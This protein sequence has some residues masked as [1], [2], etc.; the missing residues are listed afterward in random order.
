MVKSAIVGLSLLRAV[1]PVDFDPTDDAAITG[2]AAGQLPHHVELLRVQQLLLGSTPRLLRLQAV[3][4]IDSDGQ[5]GGPAVVVDPP[6]GQFDID[7]R[8][9]PIAGPL[10]GDDGRNVRREFAAA[11]RKHRE[12]LRQGGV[13]IQL[14]AILPRGRVVVGVGFTRGAGALIFK[15]KTYPFSIQGLSVLDVSAYSGLASPVDVV[16]RESGTF[17]K[18]NLRQLR[19][20]TASRPELRANL[21]PNGPLG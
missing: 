17:A 11:A 10:P 1:L 8:I 15:G 9:F 4:D 7:R 6:H 14:P 2:D 21:L 16:A 12:I 13:R 3:A 19:E 20:F 18:W 5:Q